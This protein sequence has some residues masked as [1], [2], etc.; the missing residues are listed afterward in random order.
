[1]ENIVK[2]VL[3]HVREFIEPSPKPSAVILR[4]NKLA[5]LILKAQRENLA[6]HAINE[7]KSFT[8]HISKY[9]PVQGKLILKNASN[10]VSIIIDLDQ[11]EKLSIV[12]KAITQAQSKTD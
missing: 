10:K 2:K 11:L 9:D 12:P 8:G 7:D 5:Q 1:M 4:K 3:S 6:L